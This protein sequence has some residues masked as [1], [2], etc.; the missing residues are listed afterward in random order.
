MSSD[1]VLDDLAGRD[2]R[3]DWKPP[4]PLRPA[5]VFVWP[6]QPAAFLRWLLG[7][8]GF[9]FPWG[10][11]YVSVT[12]FTWHLLTPDFSSMATIDAGWVAALAGRNLVLVAAVYSLFHVHLYTRRA[13]GLQFKYTNR[14]PATGNSTFLFSNQLAD[15]VFFT[16]AVGVPVMTGFEVLLYWAMANDDAPFI[17]FAGNELYFVA[18]FLAIPIWREFHF[19]VIHRAIHWPPLYRSVHSLHHN[20][21]NP[22]PWSGMAMHPVEMVLYFSCVLVHFVVPSHPLHVLFQL[23]LTAFS[24]AQGHAGF[25]SL[26]FGKRV[27]LKNGGFYH[28]LHHRYFECN[29]GTDLIPFDRWFGTFH[30]GSDEATERMNRRLL[31]RPTSGD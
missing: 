14:W 6:P 10:V 7:W 24:P 3:G 25:E 27:T 8:E 17:E 9:I 21:V 12:V 19:Y 29:Y 20:N 15:N 26:R 16:L 23:Q 28:Y 1:P 22:N 18:L 31:D 11:L 5:P 4:D 13:Q 2:R 30:D